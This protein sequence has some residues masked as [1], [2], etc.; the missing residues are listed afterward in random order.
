MITFQY[1]Y[2]ARKISKWSWVWHPHHG[3]RVESGYHKHESLEADNPEMN[4]DP[5][6][7]GRGWDP[8]SGFAKV[9]P[10]KREIEFY[11]YTTGKIHHEA[12]EAFKHELGLNN[13]RIVSALPD[14][15]ADRKK[16]DWI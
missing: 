11:D 8:P 3:I 10:V 9:N 4:E 15:L 6:D 7:P 12:G 1:F 5:K 2:E 13:Y 14:T 16:E